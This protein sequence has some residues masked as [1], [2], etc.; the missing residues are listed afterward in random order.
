MAKKTIFGKTPYVQSKNLPE[1]KFIFHLSKIVRFTDS[2]SPVWGIF[3]CD[4]MNLRTVSRNRKKLKLLRGNFRQFGNFYLKNL[5]KKN[6][7][8]KFHE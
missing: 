6:R 5:L 4:I 1:K 8:I 2:L 3:F 7:K